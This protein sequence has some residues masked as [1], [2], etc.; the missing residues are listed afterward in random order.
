EVAFAKFKTNTFD[1]AAASPVVRIENGGTTAAILV[2]AGL[3][4]GA[5]LF[6]FDG[7]GLPRRYYTKELSCHFMTPALVGGHLYGCDGHSAF[8]RTAELVCLDWATGEA[9]WKERGLGLTSL[10]VADGYLVI[11]NDTGTLR[12]ARASPE[13][14]EELASAEILD[15]QCWTCPVVSH[16]RVFA[17][18]TA[19]RLVCLD[20]RSDAAK[21][22]MRSLKSPGVESF[23]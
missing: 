4:T 14:Y 17:R 6:D 12:I 15:G 7:A 2:T 23:E 5:S 8:P 18:N 19:G 10:V 1:T 13:G 11:L 3:G 21:E 22:Y 16:G 9:V 20:L